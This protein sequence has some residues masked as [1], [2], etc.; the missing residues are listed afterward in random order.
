MLELEQLIIKNSDQDRNYDGLSPRSME[1]AMIGTVQV[2]V[3]GN[4]GGI[5]HPGKHYIPLNEDASNADDVVATLQNK[6]YCMDLIR[7]CR[8]AFLNCADLK[9]QNIITEVLSSIKNHAK[10]ARI[11]DVQTMYTLKKQYKKS[12]KIAK[13]YYR[14]RKLFLLPRKLKS[15]FL[16]TKNLLG[17]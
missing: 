17:I 4:Y 2:L 1:A 10:I 15:I 14:L 6:D 13:T 9:A 7:N 16:G 3:K 5:L 11:S 12:I 8:E